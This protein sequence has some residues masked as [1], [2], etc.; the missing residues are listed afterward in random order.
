M[1]VCRGTFYPGTGAADEVGRGSGAGYTVNV[2]W[3]AGNIGNGDYMA[4]M[5]QVILPIAREFAP[6]L[7]LISAGFDA[8]AGDPIGGCCLT[9]ECFGQMTADLMSV[10]PTVL[11]LEGGYNLLSTAVS[12]EACLKVLLGEQP[13]QV[14]SRPSAFGWLAI[15]AAKKAHSRYWSCLAGAYPQLHHS[16]LQQQLRLVGRDSSRGVDV[17]YEYGDDY[18][19]E[20]YQD[21]EGED[22]DSDAGEQDME[23]ERQPYQP[24]QQQEGAAD[25]AGESLGFGARQSCDGYSSFRHSHVGYSRA[26]ATASRLAVEEE[27]EGRSE[28]QQRHSSKRYHRH[29]GLSRKQQMLRAIHRQAMKSFWRRRLKHAQLRPDDDK[30]HHS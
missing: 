24:W 22:G 23:V 12:T 2:P 14:L 17:A 13:A 10:A 5:Q 20:E 16:S 1:I 4:A 29:L 15:Q 30:L 26:S 8:A 21:D 25:A 6:N 28:W 19:E 3:D 27:V 7:V 18:E 9:P 11:L